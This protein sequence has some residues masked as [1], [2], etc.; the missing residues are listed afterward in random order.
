MAKYYYLSPENSPVGPVEI[1]QLTLCGVGPDSLVW[2]E[3]MADWVAAGSVPEIMQAWKTPGPATVPLNGVPYTPSD[4]HAQPSPAPQQQPFNPAPQQSSPAPQQQNPAPEPGLIPE[5]PQ[6]L[7]GKAIA[8][9]V[10]GVCCTGIIG[11]IFGILA[12]VY[13]N[14][15]QTYYK[16]GQYSQAQSSD[17]QAHS[18]LKIGTWVSIGLAVLGFIIGFLYIFLVVGS[19]LLS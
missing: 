10:V 6:P 5:P 3:G 1:N 14:Q 17:H 18:M 8:L 15:A 2:C 9:I 12:L 4:V 7:T 16:M 13:S 11:T 19:A